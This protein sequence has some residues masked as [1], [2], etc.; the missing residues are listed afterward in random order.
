MWWAGSRDS[1]VS[2]T[3]TT[4]WRRAGGSSPATRGGPS[5]AA[6]TWR[7]ASRRVCRVEPTCG[8]PDPREQP[9]ASCGLRSVHGGGHRERRAGS[10]DAGDCRLPDAIGTRPR[11][12]RFACI[13]MN[14]PAL[15]R[16]DF[17]VIGLIRRALQ[18]RM[19]S[20]SCCRVSMQTSL[21]FRPPAGADHVAETYIQ[22][23]RSQMS[24]VSTPIIDAPT[25]Q[26]RD[27][28]PYPP[29][30]PPSSLG[31]SSSQRPPRSSSPRRSTLRC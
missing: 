31:C 28:G 2:S 4:R 7:R 10:R 5:Y 1:S 20:S 16:V 29:E 24:T 23:R 30:R 15:W 12:Q 13:E 19:R 25:M 21:P 27:R 8:R 17:T 6:A 22:T 18:R 14:R 9:H 3:S 11:R 26:Q